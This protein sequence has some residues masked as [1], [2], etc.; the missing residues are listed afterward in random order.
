[1]ETIKNYKELI[2]SSS[3]FYNNNFLKIDY[4]LCRFNYLTLSKHF[5]GDVGLEMGPAL[6]QMTKYLIEDFKEL[7][8]IEGSNELLS[9]IP[10]YPNIF[11]YNC[12]FEEFKEEICADTIIMSHVLEHLENPVGI[13]RKFKSFLNNSGVFIIS[14]PNAKS[15]HRLVAKD[16]GLLD[17][18][19]SLNERDFALGHY[20]VYDLDSLT[21]DCFEAGYE[22]VERGG[23]FLN[24]FQTIKLR[25]LGRM[26]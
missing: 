18:I 1:M 6:G 16:M 25:T 14:V 17:S 15:I 11:K 10:E 20:R 4:E 3:S 12:Y 2:K 8:V 23:V 5:R 26:K 7:H 22:V 9:Q 24:R 13:L 21:K 19:Y